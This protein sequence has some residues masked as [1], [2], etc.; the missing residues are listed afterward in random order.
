MLVGRAAY[1]HVWGVYRWQ[2]LATRRYTCRVRI[3]W[4][5]SAG[6]LLHLNM[7]VWCVPRVCIVCAPRVC[8]TDGVS[9]MELYIV[10][11][12]FWLDFVS[13]VPFVYLVSIA[14]HTHTHARDFAR[15]STLCGDRLAFLCPGTRVLL[16]CASVCVCM[17]VCV[18]HT[19]SGVHRRSGCGAH[20]LG[21]LRLTDPS[22]AYG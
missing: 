20:P 6:P 21:D 12:R 9:V 11:G 15:L 7:R 14:T 3:P 18:P 13:V 10:H 17:R 2:G 19:Y 4:L 16:V 22:R 8:Y 1:E 5:C